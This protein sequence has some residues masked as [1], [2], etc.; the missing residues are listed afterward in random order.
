MQKSKKEKKLS[1]LWKEKKNQI[2]ERKKEKINENQY[3]LT[4]GKGK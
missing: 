4:F 2:D 3:F 1:G